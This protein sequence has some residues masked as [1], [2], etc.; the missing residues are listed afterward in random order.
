MVHY[1]H[2]RKW[3]AAVAVLSFIGCV[4]IGCPASPPPDTDLKSGFRGI[5]WKSTLEDIEGMT[6]VKELGGRF[7]WATRDP[8]HRKIGSVP[9][10]AI[11]YKFIANAFSAVE[12][13]F[14]G[15]AAFKGLVRELESAWGVADLDNRQTNELVWR[16]EGVAAKL[17]YYRM[18]DAGTLIFVLNW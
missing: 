12:I 9:V 1:S 8:E 15:S 17:N 7:V 10:D 3:Y 13:R 11:E 14:S 16:L 5:A 4:L 18:P 6:V 2:A